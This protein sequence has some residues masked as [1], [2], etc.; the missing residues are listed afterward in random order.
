MRSFGRTLRA[1]RLR[2]RAR[3]ALLLSIDDPRKRD[4]P[5]LKLLLPTLARLSLA[6]GD[7]VRAQTY[8]A[9][10]LSIAC[11]VARPGRH[12]ADVGEAMLLLCKARHLAGHDDDA[13]RDIGQALD[14]LHASLGA[15]HSL[16]REA[17][18]LRAAL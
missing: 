17:R 7:P 8:A 9:D 15:E 1:I 14:D 10:A 13:R 18:S 2:I 6:E 16:T 12:S 11:S 3:R 5:L 4:I